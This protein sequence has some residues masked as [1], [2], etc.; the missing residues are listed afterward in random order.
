M[1]L[2][3]YLLFVLGAATAALIVLVIYHREPR[4]RNVMCPESGMPAE[5]E[6]DGLHAFY[7]LLRD[8]KEIRLKSCSRWPQR[9]GCDEDCLAQ[10]ASGPAIERVVAKWCN[11]KKC[12]ICAMPITRLDWQRGRAGALDTKRNLIE[13]RDMNWNEFPMVLEQ[14]EPLCWR[15]HETELVKRRQ[16][17]DTIQLA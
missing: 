8:Q 7:T 4:K 11:G 16:A 1:V 13:L 6:I 15:C 10:I 3:V 5:V 9:A 2:P 14:Y 12:A 17:R